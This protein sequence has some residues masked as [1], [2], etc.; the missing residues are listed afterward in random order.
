MR[1]EAGQL[2]DVFA[3]RKVRHLLPFFSLKKVVDLA[4]LALRGTQVHPIECWWMQGERDA[5]DLG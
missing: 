4:I 2:R 3:E 5:K 1:G